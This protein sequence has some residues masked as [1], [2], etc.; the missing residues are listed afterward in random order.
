MRALAHSCAP[1]PSGYRV[2]LAVS[3]AV[4][5]RHH[6]ADAVVDAHTQEQ[7]RLL[8]AFHFGQDRPKD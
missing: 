3:L 7:G 8:R 5:R 2:S 6:M 1:V 4:P